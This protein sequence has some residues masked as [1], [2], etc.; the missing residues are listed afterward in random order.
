MADNESKNEEEPQKLTEE[1]VAALADE[2]HVEDTV[3]MLKRLSKPI[4]LG[5]VV[6]LVGAVGLGVVRGN[7]TSADV[8]AGLRLQSADSVT[9]LQE[10]IDNF[11]ETSNAVVAQL[12]QAKQYFQDG[13]YDEALSAYQAVAAAHTGEPFNPPAVLGS[14]YTQEAKGQLDEALK[15][16]KAFADAHPG[17]Y[18]ELEARR[19]AQRCLI[20]LGQLVEAKAACEKYIADN[21]THGSVGMVEEQLAYIKTAE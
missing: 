14:L 5:V 12:T 19:G 1:Q 20:Q 18:L 21:P 10:V 2:A 17:H 15:G 4:G 16:F 7:K 11:P 3:E 9:A 8:A 6:L 13:Q